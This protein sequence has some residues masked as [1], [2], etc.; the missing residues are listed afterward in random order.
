M[1]GVLVDFQS[2][3]VGLTD[4]LTIQEMSAKHGKKSARDAYLA[5][6]IKFWA[7]LPW[8]RGGK[9][10][11]KA[12]QDLFKRVCILSSAGT[13]DPERGK[14]GDIGKRQWIKKNMPQMDDKNVFIVMGKH[15]KPNFA[16]KMSILVDDVPITIQKWNAQGGYGILHDSNHYKK[17]IETLEDI[18]RPMTLKEIIK[19]MQG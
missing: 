1:D 18:S 15:L 16:N 4:G 13:S 10:L 6:G 3:Y 9:E 8:I 17:T 5:A 14:I 12:S 19:R 11:W 2:G 7:N